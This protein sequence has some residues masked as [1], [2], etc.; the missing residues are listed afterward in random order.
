MGG[1]D[2]EC[3]RERQALVGCGTRFGYASEVGI[4]ACPGRQCER[5]LLLLAGLRRDLEGLGGVVRSEL[6]VSGQELDPTE[7]VCHVT[8][9]VLVATREHG[10]AKRSER[11]TSSIE[12]A[13]P[14]EQHPVNPGGSD[15]PED[16]PPLVFR[17]FELAGA[18]DQRNWNSSPANGLREGH[19]RQRACEHAGLLETLGEL[20]RRT[21]MRLGRRD[22]GSLHLTRNRRSDRE[23]HAQ[24][25]P[26]DPAA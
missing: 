13:C 18:L 25:G 3:E 22:G 5:P 15:A 7:V 14:L 24:N 8:Q 21:R 20:E 23:Q 4:D 17:V 11:R 1:D 6:P 19:V 26:H 12:I 10:V 16:R 2:A 9:G